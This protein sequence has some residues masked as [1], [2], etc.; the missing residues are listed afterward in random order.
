[1]IQAQDS[2]EI[3]ERVGALIGL[4]KGKDDAKIKACG[5]KIANDA[6]DN[7]A[8]FEPEQMSDMLLGDV[9]SLLPNAKRTPN[10]K[11]NKLLK[12]PNP[13]ILLLE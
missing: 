1:M 13:G 9:E 2:E 10:T 4:L 11:T 12:I 7:E 6:W 8:W 3:E 5:E